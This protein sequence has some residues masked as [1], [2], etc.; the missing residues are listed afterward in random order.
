MSPSVCDSSKNPNNWPD[1][2]KL[3]VSAMENGAIAM[4]SRVVTLEKMVGEQ[5]KLMMRLKEDLVHGNARNITC[6]LSHSLK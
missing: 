6:S 2:P 4:E 5:G 1:L 3:I